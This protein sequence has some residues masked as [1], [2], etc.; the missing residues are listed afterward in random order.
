[1]KFLKLVFVLFA[2][3]L[4]LALAAVSAG[5]LRPD[6]TLPESAAKR[7]AYSTENS[8]DAQRFRRLEAELAPCIVVAR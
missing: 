6:A 5:Y 8:S 2:I 7:T 1:M 3:T 4:I